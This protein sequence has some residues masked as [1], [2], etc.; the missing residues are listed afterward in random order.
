MAN[1]TS[2]L[3]FLGNVVYAPTARVAYIS[4]HLITTVLS[5]SVAKFLKVFEKY[6][7]EGG[8]EVTKAALR[9]STVSC[10]LTSTAE[11]KNLRFITQ[12]NLGAIR[13][14]NCPKISTRIFVR[15]TSA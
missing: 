12:D 6:F 2:V 7:L 10:L 1:L 11:H 5:P 3:Y 14:F 13:F 4:F 8:L 9:K 15:D